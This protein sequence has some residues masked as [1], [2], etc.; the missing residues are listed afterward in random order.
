MAKKLSEIMAELLPE[1][2]AKV[3]IR[4]QVLITESRRVKNI[5]KAVKSISSLKL[6]PIKM[7]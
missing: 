6:K 7:G 1:R 5:D 4:A 2:Q 3:E